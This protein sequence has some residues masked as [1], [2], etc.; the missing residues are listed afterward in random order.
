MWILECVSETLLHPC[1]SA[2]KCE[3][4]VVFLLFKNFSL[5]RYLWKSDPTLPVEACGHLLKTSH[6]LYIGVSSQ[7]NVCVWA[8]LQQKP[9]SVIMPERTS[10]S[11]VHTINNKGLYDIYK[12]ILW[13]NICNLLCSC[14]SKSTKCIVSIS[15]PEVLAWRPITSIFPIQLS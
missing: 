7:L 15:V 1:V 9:L 2:W 3:V 14:V 12:A 4:S 13:W 11:C 5:S 10:D 6:L 8:D